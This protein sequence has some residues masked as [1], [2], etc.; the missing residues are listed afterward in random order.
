MS[1]AVI[2]LL[3]FYANKSKGLPIGACKPKIVKHLHYYLH[4]YLY[5][6]NYK[7][8][9]TMYLLAITYTKLQTTVHSTTPHSMSISVILVGQFLS[10]A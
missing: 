3:V 2:L 10:T 9:Q 5:T 6:L 1:F 8:C 4:V 7:V